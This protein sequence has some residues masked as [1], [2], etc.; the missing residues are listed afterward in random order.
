MFEYSRGLIAC[1]CSSRLGVARTNAV[2]ALKQLQNVSDSLLSGPSR[3][4]NLHQ[5][6]LPT[7]SLLVML[8]AI[9]QESNLALLGAMQGRRTHIG[10]VVA[11]FAMGQKGLLVDSPQQRAQVTELHHHY[12]DCVMT[13]QQHG[14]QMCVN[15]LGPKA[16]P[17]IKVCCNTHCFCMNQY[18]DVCCK[19]WDEQRWLT[20]L[21]LNICCEY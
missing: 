6:R 18:R 7:R 15:I 9:C 5:R 21:V 17:T 12:N 14:S 13:L 11:P 20:L 3:S 2:G 19:R 4:C 16:A 1:C 10:S 8:G